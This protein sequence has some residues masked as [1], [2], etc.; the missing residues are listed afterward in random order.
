MLDRLPGSLGQSLLPKEFTALF[1]VFGPWSH[2][3]S[4]GVLALRSSEASAVLV[5]WW[6]FFYPLSDAFRSP[7]PCNPPP[8]DRDRVILPP[9]GG[10]TLLPLYGG[11]L[12]S[13]CFVAAFLSLTLFLWL[14]VPLFVAVV[15]FPP[16][17]WGDSLLLPLSFFAVER[18]KILI[19]CGKYS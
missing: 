17:L 4:G 7:L 2:R 18:N 10:S 11:Y 13:H 19:R 12:L 8:K 14:F 6:W 1:L 3:H 16:F 15:P 9:C 5:S